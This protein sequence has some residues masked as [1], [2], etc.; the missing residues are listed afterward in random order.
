MVALPTATS[1]FSFCKVIFVCSSETHQKLKIPFSVHDRQPNE[2]L[3]LCLC[4][5]AYF[6]YMH[7]MFIYVAPQLSRRERIDPSRMCLN[8]R[9]FQ[10]AVLRQCHEES[11]SACALGRNAR[12]NNAHWHMNIAI[13][14]CTW[15]HSSLFFGPWGGTRGLALCGFTVVMSTRSAYQPFPLETCFRSESHREKLLPLT[16]WHGSYP[17]NVVP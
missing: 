16:P 17:L 15:C 6:L 5:V 12:W 2:V 1:V 13:R 11:C 9:P 7:F 14:T 3:C 4:S 10:R 8:K